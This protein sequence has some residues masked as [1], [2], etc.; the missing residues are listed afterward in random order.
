MT[1]LEAIGLSLA[2]GHGEDRFK[3]CVE[4]LVLEAGEMVSVH[5]PSGIGKSSLLEL[6]A[7]VVRPDSAERL[8]LTPKGKESI[9]LD[10]SSLDHG[11]L[12]A[13]PI[14]FGPQSGGLL[15]FLS[16]RANARAGLA[17]TGRNGVPKLMERFSK[18]VDGL[19][20]ENCLDRNRGEL[21]GGERKR[22]ALLRALAVPR[23]LMLL[24]E[25]TAGLDDALADRAMK[26]V[27]EVCRQEGTALV[28]AM[29]DLERSRRFGLAQLT[30][31]R[32]NGGAVLP[33]SIGTLA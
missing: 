20:L 9:N 15:G 13:G 33:R 10:D 25:P 30:L 31:E 26:V 14:G 18:L 6:L 28:V 21:S 23:T 3:L 16:A 17:L 19:G 27:T 29:H 2:R 4:K 32:C 7:C 8:V 11:P 1:V 5:G 12:R 24:D 22:V